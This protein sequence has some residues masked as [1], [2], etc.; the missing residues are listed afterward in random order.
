M[1]DDIIESLLI[2]I[3]TFTSLSILILCYNC[4]CLSPCIVFNGF[5]TRF[6]FQEKDIEKQTADQLS[7]LVGKEK[8]ME[9]V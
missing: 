1:V 5:S 4:C 2:V 9:L 3:T 7:N 6:R 8:N